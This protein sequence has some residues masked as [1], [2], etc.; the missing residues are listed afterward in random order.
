LRLI[1]QLFF[2]ESKFQRKLGSRLE[3]YE[4]TV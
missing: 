3:I 2:V 1:P 4:Y